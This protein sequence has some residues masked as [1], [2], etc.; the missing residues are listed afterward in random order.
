[1]AIKVPIGNEIHQNVPSQGLLKYTKI[2]ILV[3]KYM[4]NLAT[5]HRQ[6]NQILRAKD[7]K[8]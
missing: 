6:L 2:G 7:R 4:Y 8:F 1:M 5:L 3:W